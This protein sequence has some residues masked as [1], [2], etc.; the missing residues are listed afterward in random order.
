VRRLVLVVLA[1]LAAAALSGCGP[2]TSLVS[3]DNALNNAG[4][5]SSRLTFSGNSIDVSV[6][7]AAPPAPSDVDQVL[8]IVWSHFHER[9]DSVQVNV[10]GTGTTLSQEYTF[11]EVQQKLGP[12][13]P[14]WNRTTITG[15]AG[16]AAAIVFGTL[17]GAA[18]IV[19][20][21]VL[22]VT[23][24]NRRRRPP[25]PGGT[26]G[27]GGAW[28]A[29]PHWPQPPYPPPAHPPYPPPAQPPYPPG[30]GPTGGGPPPGG[31]PPGGGPPQPPPAP[32]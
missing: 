18:I 16:Q 25:W 23:R 17:F 24:R 28:G 4:F 32:G 21:V 30:G 2:V 10:H 19:V 8:S 9:F 5:Q 22:L 27:P 12:R 31:G 26:G 7:V 20:A 13:D 6:T 3:T 29:G 14:A 1:V 11:D 15:A